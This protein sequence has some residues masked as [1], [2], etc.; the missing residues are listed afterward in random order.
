MTLTPEILALLTLDV[1]FFSFG[2]I[3]FATSI[4]ILKYWD[5]DA[6]TALQYRLEKRAYLV[7]III[8]YIFVIKLPLFL[9]FIYT[10]DKLSAI[11]TGAMCATGVVNAVDFGFYLTILKVINLYGFGF[12]LLLYHYDKQQPIS[13]YTKTLLWIFCFLFFFLVL[14]IGLEMA[15]F[16]KLDVSKI[17]SCCGTLFSSAS[18]S[19]TSLLFYVDSR[20]WL[21]AFY[22]SALLMLLATWLKKPMA[23]LFS[24]LLYLMFAIISLILFFSTYV[25]ELPTHHCP[26]CLLQ[27]EYYGVGYLLYTLLFLGTFYGIAG[28]FVMMVTHTNQSAWIKRSLGFNGLYML[29]ISLYPL[30]Y[31]FKNGVWL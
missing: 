6:S 25:Y 7:G 20:I 9:F 2:T 19:Y 30:V 21:M 31:Y 16:L 24:N 3:A 28:S 5:L 4:T 18:T 26:F 11:I 22:G 13:A 14:E 8:K 15:F 27:K 17:V 23:M 1:L 29:L 12:W 10:V